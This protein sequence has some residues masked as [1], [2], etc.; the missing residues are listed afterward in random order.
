MLKINEFR[1]LTKK[2]QN[3][4]EGCLF[5]EAERFHASGRR[6]ESAR[7]KPQLYGFF[8]RFPTTLASFCTN[9]RIFCP[10]SEQDQERSSLKTLFSIPTRADLHRA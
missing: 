8:E 9:F 4:P 3:H 2:H 5:D 10:N 6:I 7:A 1:P